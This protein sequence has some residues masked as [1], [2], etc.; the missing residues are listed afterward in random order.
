MKSPTFLGLMIYALVLA[1]LITREGRILVLAIPIL[2]YLAA[3][4]LHEPEAPRFEISR[5]LNT[6]RVTPHQPV[7]VTLTLT[8]TGP[9]L[10]EVSLEDVIP[11]TLTV[12][13]GAPT[14]LARVESG[15]TINLT[16]TVVG[17][18]GLYRFS[19]MRVTA[20][21]QFGLFRKEIILQAPAQ[22]F[23]LPEIVKV[24]QVAIR[25]RRIKVYNGL[26]PARQ[27]G[28]GVEFF[29]VREY[30]SGD[31]LRWINAR[32]SA[33][34]DD[35]L[36]INEYEQ[37]RVVDIGLIL[38]ARHQS[39][40]RVGPEALFEYSVQ[41]AATL[42]E[43]FINSGNRVGLLIYG[44]S[45]D[46]TFPGYGKIQQE[47]IFRA[48]ARAQQGN[49]K[50]FERLEHI[51]TRLFPARSQIVFI[52]PLLGDDAEMLIK[53]R[54]RGYQMMVISPDPISFEQQNFAPN[55]DVLLAIQFAR[56]ERQ[57]ILSKLAH[58]NVQVVDWPVK[59]PFYQMA[60][61]ALSRFP[62]QRG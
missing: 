57:L 36:F 14:W 4:L 43:T 56:F 8:N 32:T 24:R 3:G 10:E 9:S 16:Y 22:F 48:L 18:R 21:E 39:D 52:S 61:I 15:Q 13:E 41:A 23:V 53:L 50:I 47:R 42:A 28:P 34:Y 33:R 19:D 59:T 62:F 25:P 27:G 54:A 58:A 12:V 17:R 2:I 45:I 37:E 30:Q 46:W 49:G 5:N 29:G 35:K 40:V 31:P 60:H 1:A 51:P 6:D 11:P 44:R 38:D 20:T 7:V 26:I 55:D